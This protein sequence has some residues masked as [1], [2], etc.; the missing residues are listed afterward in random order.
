[1]SESEYTGPF[2][3]ALEAPVSRK[4]LSMRPCSSNSSCI[5][6]MLEATLVARRFA[7]KPSWIV[8]ARTGTLRSFA[9]GEW[10]RFST[11]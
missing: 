10:A 8:T 3:G 6:G 9:Y 7:Q 4:K 11:P 2:C 1:M 5:D